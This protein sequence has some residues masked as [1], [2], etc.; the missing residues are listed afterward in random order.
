MA[1]TS[2]QL[3]GRPFKDWIR[4][5]YLYRK[6]GLLAIAEDSDEGLFFVAGDMY[7]SPEHPLFEQATAW[8]DAPTSFKSIAIELLKG[9]P[10]LNAAQTKF[11]EGAA[12]IRIDLTGPL[13]TCQLIMESTVWDADEKAL[14][15][16]LGG[17][18]T[19]LV[20][21]SASEP[22]PANIDL[23][24]HEAF[25]L[26]RLESPQAVGELLHQLD[27]DKE[28]VLRRLCRL[29]SIN[30][31]RQE[32]G[33]TVEPAVTGQSGELLTR[34]L[35][36]IDESL[37]REPLDL[38][39]AQHRELL[40]NLIGRIGEISHFEL[41]AV[42]PQSTDDEIHK[43]YFEL[44]RLVHPS[45]APRLGLEGKEGTLQILF[46]RATDAYLTVSD[47][48]RKVRYANEISS[49]SQT[50]AND[51]SD[52]QRREEIRTV[53]RES[54]RSALSLAERHEYH[55]AIQLL[56][57][58]VKVDPQPEYLSLLGDCQAENP[59]WL[60]RAAAN[61]GRAVRF[62]PNDPF[63]RIK[64]GRVYELQRRPDRARPEYET[65]LEL[66]PEQ[67][68]AMAGLERIGA[69]ISTPNKRN[70]ADR[71]RAWLNPSERT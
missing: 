43:G 36:R 44:G 71:L 23:D 11:S 31:V 50:T 68:E 28:E 46:E 24:P 20:V 52:D 7:L 49:T 9:V 47:P 17:E 37:Q 67:P 15:R 8:V 40:K 53:A 45:Q 56:E 57:Q 63:L 70:L 42:G 2:V 29:L 25:L 26:S 13:P 10:D 33:T 32:L 64:L 62:R 19:I 69:S 58:A 55:S 18:E 54:Y 27:I 3:P 21:S 66:A 34:F 48:E 41:L 59:K 51:L 61:Y 30:L 65:A 5:I 4:D 35:E 1:N 38:D 22:L 14:L 12:Q 6:T 16:Q 60:D 39:A